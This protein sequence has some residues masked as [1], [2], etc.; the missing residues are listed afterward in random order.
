MK[1]KILIKIL[2]GLLVIE[3]CFFA[4][5]LLISIYARKNYVEVLSDD[6]YWRAVVA[7]E[8]SYACAGFLTFQG[9]EENVKLSNEKIMINWVEISENDEFRIVDSLF[10]DSRTDILPDWFYEKIIEDEQYYVFMD[11]DQCCDQP[12][13]LMDIKWEKNGEEN[14][15]HIEIKYDKWNHLNLIEEID[16]FFWNRGYFLNLRGQINV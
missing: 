11:S 8:T 4:F 14:E 5:F 3:I 1:G 9:D 15:S 6:G 13:I 16:C 2:Y 12:K 7:P 10:P